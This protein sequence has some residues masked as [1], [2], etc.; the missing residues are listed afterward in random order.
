MAKFKQTL[1][2]VLVSSS[3][4]SR[5]S[6]I[7]TCQLVRL[8]PWSKAWQRRKPVVGKTTLPVK[9]TLA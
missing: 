4:S 6:G 1:N 8:Q 9:L 3:P 2:F 5:W 7:R